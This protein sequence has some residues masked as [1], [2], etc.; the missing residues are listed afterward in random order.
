VD[1]TGL[2]TVLLSDTSQITQLDI[3]KSWHG[4]PMMGLTH[5]LRALASCPTL[6]KLGLR[7]FALGREGVNLLRLALY[8]TTNL[9]SLDLANSLLEGA[10]G[11]QN[12]HQRCICTHHNTS[13]KELNLAGNSLSDEW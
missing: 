5:V 2:D 9:Q 7:D 13:I 10:P 3:E 11:W 1:L 8:S 6:T 4:L 12:F